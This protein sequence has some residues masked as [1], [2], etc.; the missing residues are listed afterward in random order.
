M[1]ELLSAKEDLLEQISTQ[2]CVHEAV[3]A[4]LERKS[5]E[6][7]AAQQL[8]MQWQKRGRYLKPRADRDKEEGER[9]MMQLEIECLRLRLR[10]VE[11]DCELLRGSRREGD[12][13][14]SQVIGREEEEDGDDV[15]DH[16]GMLEREIGK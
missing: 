15:G 7:E 2:A 12:S 4:D 10:D 5:A 16:V 1:E 14:M 6:L 11:R 13:I 3:K 8:V 9:R